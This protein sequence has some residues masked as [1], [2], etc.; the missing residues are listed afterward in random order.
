MSFLQKFAT[1]ACHRISS[2]GTLAPSREP[3]VRRRPQRPQPSASREGTLPPCCLTAC[4]P[5]EARP[6]FAA[7]CPRRAP[8]HPVFCDESLCEKRRPWR[9]LTGESRANLCRAHRPKV[10]S[11]LGAVSASLADDAFRPRLCENSSA[12]AA[13]VGHSSIWSICEPKFASDR[14]LA[15]VVRRSFP[16]RWSFHTAWT[17]CSHKLARRDRLLLS[18]HASVMGHGM[19]LTPIRAACMPVAL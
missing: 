15:V 17:R 13:D 6:L 7:F 8:V 9:R 3:T 2:S 4:E 14:T 12:L 18:L 5:R 1:A 16:P 19:G 11:Q 10:P